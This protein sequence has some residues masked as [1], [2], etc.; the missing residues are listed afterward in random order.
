MFFTSNPIHQNSHLK[1][2]T[3][4][5]LPEIHQDNTKQYNIT[6]ISPKRYEGHLAALL[7]DS[8]LLRCHADSVIKDV[9]KVTGA[10][11]YSVSGG[12]TSVLPSACHWR[13]RHCDPFETSITT[14]RHS[15][16]SHKTEH[17]C[18]TLES[19]S[20]R[21]CHPAPKNKMP[22]LTRILWARRT[23][24]VIFPSYP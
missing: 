11:T 10:L 7:E 13:W 12:P 24:F 9:S 20:K 2:L 8:T 3:F 4:C 5:C 22:D 23:A 21:Q 19:E 15:I 6:Y 16:A 14:S 18:E 1:I 17:R